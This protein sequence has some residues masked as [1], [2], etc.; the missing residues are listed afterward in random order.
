MKIGIIA[1]NNIRY[2]PY[3][4]FYTHILDEIGVNYELIYPNRMKVDDEFDHPAHIIKWNTK[5]PVALS[6]YVYASDVKKIVKR[7]KYDFLIVLTM[8]NAVYLA[9]WLKNNY[10]QKYILDIRDYTHENIDLY[11]HFEKIAVENSLLNVISSKKFESFL[12]I[13]NYLTCHNMNSG[14]NQNVPVIKRNGTITIAYIGKGGYL[15]NCLSLCDAVSNDK[16]F[17]FVFYGLNIIPEELKKYG[18]CDNITFNGVFLPKEKEAI[19]LSSDILFNVYGNGIP[20]LDYALSNKLYDSFVYR[21]PILTSPNTYMSEVAGPYAFDVDLNK[22]VNL[23]DLYEWYTNL[24]ETLID[25]YAKSKIAEFKAEG[26]QTINTIKS[27]IKSI[28]K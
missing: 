19:I 12:P 1:A 3:I 18:E 20:L 16:R 5:L 23:N 11:F 2:S 15:N 7:E 10:R 26:E 25:D 21:K 9:Q 24:D 13:G 4:F 14:I 28:N 6:Y 17:R 27:S 8:N 22:A